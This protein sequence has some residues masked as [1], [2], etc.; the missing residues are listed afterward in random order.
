MRALSAV[1][2][3]VLKSVS[4]VAR[5]LIPRFGS[6]NFSWK[7][8]L[9]RG[10]NRL[11][12]VADRGV[13]WRDDMEASGWSRSMTYAGAVPVKAWCTSRHSLYWMRASAGSQ[14]RSI[15]AEV[16]WSWSSYFAES[17]RVEQQTRLLW[18]SATLILNSIL[19]IVYFASL[20]TTS[21]DRKDSD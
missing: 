9:M 21:N 13:A 10:T 17:V 18:T 15:A 19:Y 12:V 7:R 16:T 1:A 14:W 11:S 6:S 20:C 4:V 2:K 8:S 3:L 5:Q